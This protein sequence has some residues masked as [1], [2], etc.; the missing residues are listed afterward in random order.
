MTH[1]I[2]ILALPPKRELRFIFQREVHE[3]SNN[4]VAREI[5]S[6]RPGPTLCQY[7]L[8]PCMLKL[9]ATSPFRV[10]ASLECSVI[11]LT[12]D[13]RKRILAHLFRLKFKCRYQQARLVVLRGYFTDFEC[14]HVAFN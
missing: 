5:K 7:L 10:P 13:N 9:W 1:D 3:A 14:T 2:R 4:R 12:D 6:F 8:Y 11:E